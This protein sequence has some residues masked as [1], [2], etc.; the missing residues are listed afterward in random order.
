MAFPFVFSVDNFWF[1]CLIDRYPNKRLLWSL[2]FLAYG[3]THVLI[4]LTLQSS[5]PRNSI[6]HK[7]CLS[8]ITSAV[9]AAISLLVLTKPPNSVLKF[10]YFQR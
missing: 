5:G 7:I 4:F 8:V 1:M 2:L 9:S 3:C 10:S 6:V